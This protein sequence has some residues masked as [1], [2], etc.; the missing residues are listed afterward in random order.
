MHSRFFTPGGPI[1][2]YAGNEADVTAYVN[3]TGLMWENAEAFGALVVFA[4][5]WGK[6]G[7]SVRVM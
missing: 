5:V 6:C 7:Q 3:A 4:E 1:F 2:F